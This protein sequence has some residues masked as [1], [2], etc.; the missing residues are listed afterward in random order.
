MKTCGTEIKKH[1]DISLDMIKAPAM[2]R[3]VGIDAGCRLRQH[4]LSLGLVPGSEIRVVE[5]FGR[6]QALV[7][8]FNSK[9]LL[10]R[11]VMQKILVEPKGRKN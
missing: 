10:G 1:T 9:T 6:G 5:S 4:L 7:E 3:V 11:G 8:I 2:V